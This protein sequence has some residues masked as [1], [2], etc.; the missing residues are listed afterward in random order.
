MCV[1][2]RPTPFFGSCGRGTR[3]RRRRSG[4]PPTTTKG[5]EGGEEAFLPGL[6]AA[7]RLVAAAAFFRA[8]V[9]GRAAFTAIHA[10]PRGASRLQIGAGARRKPALPPSLARGGGQVTHSLSPDAEI[11]RE[12]ESYVF[13]RWWPQSKD[14][15]SSIGPS[16]V[17]IQVFCGD[18][19]CASD[20]VEEAHS[21]SQPAGLL[22][23]SH[24]TADVTFAFGRVGG[25]GL[26]D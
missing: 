8:L 3:R 7:K 10:A 6:E 2:R 22:K 16:Q 19:V 18:V 20:V 13:R 15:F 12:K 25:R 23:S 4:P 26:S 1:P 21:R 5:R 17:D 24:V 9:L 14:P 11:N